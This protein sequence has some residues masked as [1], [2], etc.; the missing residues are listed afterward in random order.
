MRVST[1]IAEAIK[2]N[3]TLTNLD[4]SSSGID[5]AGATCIAKAIKVNKTLT[6]LDL[7]N[8]SISAAGAHIYC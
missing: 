4:L 7:F 3:K 2:V 5:D 6:D 8:N 1:S